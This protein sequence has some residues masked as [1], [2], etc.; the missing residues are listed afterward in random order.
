MFMLI[1]GTSGLGPKKAAAKYG[2]SEQRYY[3]LL[4][5]FKEHGHSALVNQ[6]TGPKQNSVCTEP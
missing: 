4:H 3:Q 6:K 1:E 2:F 5:A